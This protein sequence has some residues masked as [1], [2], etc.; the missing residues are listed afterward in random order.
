M[1]LRSTARCGPRRSRTTRFQRRVTEET[2]AE[3]RATLPRR[4][5]SLT[6]LSGGVARPSGKL[7]SHSRMLLRSA[8]A[9]PSISAPFARVSR[10]FAS[11]SS[12]FASISAGFTSGPSDFAR[13]PSDSASVP[14][15]GPCRSGSRRGVPARLPSSAPDLRR[16][17]SFP[18]VSAGAFEGAEDLS[19]GFARPRMVAVLHT[20]AREL[21]APPPTPRALPWTTS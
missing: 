16:D 7:A 12:D 14:S 4:S 1:H 11:F 10:S 5:G 19:A 8:Q 17:A 18:P 2:L 20:Q 13:G 15:S 9:L 21:H 3:H 6:R